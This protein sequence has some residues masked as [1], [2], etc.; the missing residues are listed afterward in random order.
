MESKSMFLRFGGLT[1]GFTGW[2]PAL[3]ADSLL[4]AF[5]QSTGAADFVLN[6]Y[7]DPEVRIPA[8]LIYEDH[9]SRVYWKDGRAWMEN[10]AHG[11]MKTWGYSILHAAWNEPM[12]LQIL[13]PTST[14]QM[15]H[16]L[17][18]M[19]MESR[20]LANDRLILHASVIRQ[21]NH[22]ILFSAPSGTGKST[23]AELWR[24]Y[25]DA[26]ILNGDR[27]LLRCDGD[28][29]L[30]CGLPFA[31]T[32]AICKDFSHPIRAIVVLR[33]GT[34]NRAEAM[35]PMEAIKFLL[36]QISLQRWNPR[37]L[38]AVIRLA[39]RLIAELPIYRFSCLPEK[40]AVEYLRQVL[41]E[42]DAQK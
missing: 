38:E 16:V 28:E 18:G 7:H 26:E 39:E 24:Q 21:K 8:P 1:F 25:A 13:S 27:V 3:R 14:F 31:G 41:T 17:S 29:L 2:V 5:V 9:F 20:L 4:P 6:I 42:K 40:S 23:Q 12:R 33:Q 11:T 22:V 35:Q 10:S 32:S 34:E 15:E 36:S 37:D 19:M 30:A